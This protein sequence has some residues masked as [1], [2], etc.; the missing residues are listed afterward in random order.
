MRLRWWPPRPTS[1]RWW[2]WGM[3]CVLVGLLLGALVFLA[4][5]YEEGL[6]LERQQRRANEAAADVR[7]GL[8]RNLQN[9]VA[10]HNTL[11][12]TD[13]WSE[14]A[15]QILANH[16]EMVHLTW[17]D[18]ELQVKAERT[19][20]FQ[21]H[22]FALRPRQDARFDVSQACA[23][24]QR[25]NGA[26]YASS[27]FW[28]LL[29]GTGVELMEMCLPVTRDGAPAGFLVATYSLSGLLAELVS[30][31]VRRGQR[32]AWTEAD[33][34]RLTII[35]D[36]PPGSEV[37]H[38]QQLF[39]LPGV[40]YVIRTEARREVRGWFPHILTVAVAALAL[41]LSGVLALFARDLRRRQRAESSLA[42]AL[43][44]RKAMEDS[45]VTGLRARDMDGRITYVNPA[46]CQMVGLTQEQLL[47][48]GVPAPY[49]PPEQ[50]DEYRQRMAV[51]LAGKVLPR[52]GYESEF[53]RSDG[54][55]FPVLIIEAP[56]IDARG[57]Q[58][59]WMSAVLD[60]SEQR[61]SEELSRTSQER[62][63]ATARLAMAGEM[64]SLISHELNQPLA[65]IASYA[66]GSLNLIAGDLDPSPATGGRQDVL[67]ALHRIA[68][69]AERAG[70]VIQ[71]VA[72]L[73]R[74]RDR[75]REA[76]PVAALFDAI[77]P[78]LQLQGRK[79]GIDLELTVA[80]ECPSVWCDR[81]MVEQA[82]LNLARN[83]MQAMPVGEPGTA[84][85]LR[86]LRVSARKVPATGRL[87]GPRW[88]EFQVADHGPGLTPEQVQRMFTPFFTTKPEG[89]GLGLNLCRTV[90]EQHGGALRFEANRPQGTV[91]VFTLPAAPAL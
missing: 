72:D 73:V 33:G 69:Q 4:R 89:M 23:A 27:Y 35:G 26:A 46:F 51:R 71:S 41:A 85:G 44:F 70:K 68:E 52:E 15:A 28:P 58:T 14:G 2:L 90:V 78:L 79:L 39:D 64:A 91:F 63:Q 10:L 13:V 47:G 42:E 30:P 9:L 56:L 54:T 29:Q 55:R 62:L 20:P 86:R 74:R 25:Y 32:L 40:T 12:S 31:E 6:A 21:P 34:T 80:P 11:Y 84:S 48:T 8:L 37:I 77:S 76:V 65:A 43:A 82:L 7:S 16:R 83:G 38:A 57:V 17:L 19:S 5:E 87:P 3:L 49:W 1:R 24:A 22:L 36:L 45:L 61:R 60:L 75:A 67:V 50:V 53:A 59:G 88:V 18:P 66:S 81:T